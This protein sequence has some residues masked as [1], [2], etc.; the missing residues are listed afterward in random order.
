MERK[1]TRA[2][3]FGF[4]AVSVSVALLLGAH[5]AR[6][7]EGVDAFMRRAEPGQQATIEGVVSAVWP[8][9]QRLGVIDAEEFRKC[10]V[11]TCAQMTLPVLWSGQMP[12][13]AGT[14]HA[15]GEVKKEGDGLVF[16]AG[17]M[18][19]VAPPEAGE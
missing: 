19:V 1:N 4:F 10:G 7:A 11:V 13:V 15:T 14:V 8:K 12:P 5:P 6:S 3:L 18:E 2:R 16:V 17:R 9:E